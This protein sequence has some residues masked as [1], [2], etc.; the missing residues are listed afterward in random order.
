MDYPDN[1][2]RPKEIHGHWTITNALCV[3]EDKK[4]MVQ[5]QFFGT[6]AGK[7]LLATHTLDNHVHV[8]LYS[9][10]PFRKKHILISNY[11]VK[12]LSPDGECAY[13]YVL[14]PTEKTFDAF[15]TF[16]PLQA[17]Q[18]I[19]SIKSSDYKLEIEIKFTHIENMAITNFSPCWNC[20]S[21][22]WMRTDLPSDF[23]L[24]TPTKKFAVHKLLM[25]DRIPAIREKLR[26]NSEMTSFKVKQIDDRILKETI[27]FIYS[28]RNSLTNIKDLCSL[29]KAGF[30]LEVYSLSIKCEMALKKHVEM[31]G[32]IISFRPNE[33]P[34]IVYIAESAIF[35]ERDVLL[36]K[37]LSV[38][39]W[40]GCNQELAW[41]ELWETAKIRN[42]NV[43]KAMF[44]K[45]GSGL[46]EIEEESEE[47][48]DNSFYEH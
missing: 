1:T 30:A 15:L 37:T 13:T 14:A 9:N 12:L 47:D 17:S 7:Y 35:C 38:L 32:N 22:D 26:K 27:N 41:D 45:N 23:E 44:A 16:P 28:G 3:G 42:I 6:D 43:L 40:L 8:N 36:Y 24:I 18:I 31:I 10:Y 4:Q 5:Q 2:E 20:T 46:D 25:S 21:Y 34:S 29:M 11:T 33:D 39:S 19:S 48:S